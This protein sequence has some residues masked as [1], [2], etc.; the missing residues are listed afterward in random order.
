MI[1]IIQSLLARTETSLGPIG[2][3]VW[4]TPWALLKL[5]G[6]VRVQPS[7]CMLRCMAPKGP[8]LACHFKGSFALVSRHHLMSV[9]RSGVNLSFWELAAAIPR[10]V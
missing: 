7:L 8:L 2:R 9:R 1:P 5:R 4:D 10:P 3:M 6:L